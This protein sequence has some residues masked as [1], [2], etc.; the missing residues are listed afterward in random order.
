MLSGHEQTLWS[1]A[2]PNAIAT[3]KAKELYVV[4]QRTVKEWRI[5]IRICRGSEIDDFGPHPIRVN[6]LADGKLPGFE[7]G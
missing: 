7:G 5:G 2:R 4:A 1:S 3:A 6:P